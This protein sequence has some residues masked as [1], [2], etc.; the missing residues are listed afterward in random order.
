MHYLNF[1][2]DYM[3]KVEIVTKV[4][5]IIFAIS[6]IASAKEKSAPLSNNPN[7]TDPWTFGDSN[8]VGSENCESNLQLATI[9]PFVI[10]AALLT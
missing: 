4:L 9:N 1:V 10:S 5:L 8:T 2:W 7:V 6:S 3:K